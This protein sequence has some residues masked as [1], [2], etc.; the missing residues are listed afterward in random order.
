MFGSANSEARPMSRRV[1]A[2]LL[3]AMSWL[4][5]SE[6][7]AQ[8]RQCVASG[9]GGE[10]GAKTSASAEIALTWR[11]GPNFLFVD[12]GPGMLSVVCAAPAVAHP[13]LRDLVTTALRQR[14]LDPQ[15]AVVL[16]TQP[17][18]CD[19]LFYLPISNDVQG[20]GY[21]HVESAQ[22]F[23]E[24]PQ[25]RLEGIAFLNDFAY[26]KQHPDEFATAFNHE[27]AH[28]W[29]ARVQV[30]H[31]D[32]QENAL[33]GRQ[34][35]HWSYFL[36]SGG[37]PL[38]G[39][40]WQE[41]EDGRYVA[42]PTA[43]GGVFSPLDLYLMGVLAPEEVPPFRLLL[44]RALDELHDCFGHALNVASPPQFCE[45]Q[46]IQARA[47][48]LTFADVLAVEGPRV[49]APKRQH[50]TLDVAF[51]VVLSAEEELERTECEA[52]T[53]VLPKRTASFSQ[54]SGGRVRLDNVTQLGGA[55]E[56]TTHRAR[57]G[58]ES[59]CDATP[60]GGASAWPWAVAVWIAAGGWLHRR[61]RAGA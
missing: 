8:A 12:A 11:D 41:G 35:Q 25:S 54:A 53:S 29:G 40:R 23:D 39:N 56:E 22:L 30:S 61:R 19:P 57:P 26:W 6:L 50:A 1:T 24:S 31:P 32:L 36:D 7:Q 43:P 4:G 17:I 21:D 20:L 13:A 10:L 46:S 55:C 3:G 58:A 33:L 47:V 16:G 28:R 48:E 44:P 60:A 37:S 2:S 38:E 15:V 51:L 45:A 49:P 5:A 59:G 42:V 34:A 9:A 18:G 14:G 52:L 27:L